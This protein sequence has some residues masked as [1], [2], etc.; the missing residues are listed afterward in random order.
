MYTGNPSTNPIDALRLKWGDTDDYITILQN[1][2][3]QYLI[4]KFPN[5]TRKQE[6]EAGKLLLSK[7]AHTSLRERVG[8]EERF[9]QE[10]FNNFY[11]LIKDE[12][13]NPSFGNVLPLI[14]CGGVNRC[15][16]AEIATDTTLIDSPFFRGQQSGIPDWKGYREFLPNQVIEPE[17]THYIQ[18]DV[19]IIT[20]EH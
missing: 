11:K 12:L 20:D 19:E 15:E 4:D 6:L 7:L 17:E 10:V 8:Q 13:S 16:T 5:K 2:E 18:A 1:S 9:G 3:Y 14:Y